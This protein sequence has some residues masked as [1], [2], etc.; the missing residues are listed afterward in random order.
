MSPFHHSIKQKQKQMEVGGHKFTIRELCGGGGQW[1]AIG[2]IPAN[3]S[4]Q[5]NLT[6]TVDSKT[7]FFFH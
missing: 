1:E 4:D 6:E 2:T 3:I 7:P 5:N